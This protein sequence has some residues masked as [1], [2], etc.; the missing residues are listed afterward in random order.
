M[1]YNTLLFKIV[2]IFI[3]GLK[4]SNILNF[5]GLKDKQ[6]F[7]YT[8]FMWFFTNLV[9]MASPLFLQPHFSQFNI[10]SKEALSGFSY[11]KCIFSSWKE[12]TLIYGPFSCL[13]IVLFGSIFM[14]DF[15][16]FSNARSIF[17]LMRC[18]SNLTKLNILTLLSSDYRAWALKLGE[19]LKKGQN[20]FISAFANSN[21]NVIIFRTFS[22]T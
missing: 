15:V 16:F 19:H 22:V 14:E 9:T 17:E 2:I 3:K 5:N 20:M 12:F 6:Y 8:I 4:C 11:K 10:W 1:F 21:F 18:N 13:I 7:L